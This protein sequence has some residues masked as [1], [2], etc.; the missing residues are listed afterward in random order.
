MKKVQNQKKIRS[1]KSERRMLVIKSENNPLNQESGNVSGKKAT[2]RQRGPK[3]F[4]I[5]VWANHNNGDSDISVRALRPEDMLWLF[6]K[7]I[8]IETTMPVAEFLSLVW[9]LR[10]CTD[11][12]I[13][14][15]IYT[16]SQEALMWARGYGQN[17]DMQV[18]TLTEQ[19]SAD[20]SE[21]IE[22]LR[23]NKP[24]NTFELW[25]WREMS[26]FLDDLPFDLNYS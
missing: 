22:W 12:G 17:P 20:V 16:A 9:A 24:K 21:A 4:D 13:T 19:N 2:T 23:R 11:Y 5:C 8:P 1:R 18:P 7:P 25:R 26:E 15:T 10:Y 3:R 6:N 14:G